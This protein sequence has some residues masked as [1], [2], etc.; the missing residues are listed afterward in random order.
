MY[1]YNLCVWSEICE[2]LLVVQFFCVYFDVFRLANKQDL[3]GAID[4]LDLVEN[5]DVEQAANAMKCPTRV[6]TC[7]CIYDKEQS[8]NSDMGIKNGYKWVCDY[9]FI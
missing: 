5:L 7:S 9:K 2:I 3:N 6:E 4:E 1:I 8:R